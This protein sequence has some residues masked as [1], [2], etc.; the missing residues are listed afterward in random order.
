MAQTASTSQLPLCACCV[1]TLWRSRATQF[2]ANQYQDTQFS[3]ILGMEKKLLIKI[4]NSVGLSRNGK[5]SSRVIINCL[6]TKSWDAASWQKRT[7]SSMS[8]SIP[9]ALIEPAVRNCRR[10]SAPCGDGTRTRRRQYSQPITFLKLCGISN[11][12]LHFSC[13]A[14]LV[15]YKA[16]QDDSLWACK[17]FGRG[18]TLR[19]FNRYTQIDRILR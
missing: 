9:V 4:C 11:L 5:S 1:L 15:D 12:T 8:G 7:I 16:E 10:P 17:W 6:M 13:Y 14:F 18:W 2:E 3:L 19:E